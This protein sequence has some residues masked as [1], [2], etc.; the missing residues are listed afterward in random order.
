MSLPEQLTEYVRACFSAIW[1]ETQES[2]EA[3][4]AIRQLCL[5]QHWSCAHWNVDR[6]LQASGFVTDSPTHSPLAAIRAT[7]G[8]TTPGD[9]T[10]IVLENFHRFLASPE[11]V[12]ALTQEI[13]AGKQSRTIFVILA[14]IVQIPIELDKL[15][16][17]VEHEL[18]NRDQL[19][20]IARGLAT[21]ESEMPPL[22]E[23]D[24]VLDAA[25]GL[26]R[27]E[28][29]NAFSLS[30]VRHGRVTS[31]A[32]WEL[33]SGLLKK[34]G[35]LELHRGTDDFRSLGGLTALKSFCQRALSPLSR[36]YPAIRSRGVLL[37]SPPGCGKS[38]FCK[39]LGTEVGRP[40]L[41]LDVGSLMGSLVGQ[42]EERTR[43]ALKI[44][45]AMAPCVCMID[46]VEKAF[47]G[48]NGSGDSGVATRMFGRFLSWLND[49]T[50]DVF[51]ICTANDIT[52][53]PPE[54]GRSERFDGI[55]FLDLPSR[56]EKDAIW[57]IY[58]DQ[59]GIDHD[60]A[61]PDD[62]QWTGAEVKACCRL[63]V[64]LGISLVEAAQNVVPVA[65]TAAESLD[66][67]RKWADGRCLSAH[68]SG[69]YRIAPEESGSGS[70]R[71]VNRDASMN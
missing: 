11:V 35:L 55:F 36:S 61:R 20:E 19:A 16:V 44:I 42:S 12:Q 39:C 4:S 52:C 14:P 43:Q 45:D 37:L 9:T 26:T 27:L 65:V 40:V 58:R 31:E 57:T 46:E 66:R 24:L 25:T 28:A 33:K 6:G 71:K 70:R 34:S 5:K 17:V 21:E 67:L 47:A 49:H 48:V 51:V 18:P 8:L 2:H 53:L 30:L 1:V 68:Q 50:S 56:D 15:F 54:F 7:K 29:E 60:Q 63:S 32:I 13:L 22:A 23:L 10:L 3:L 69:V 41:I 38:Q 64:L 62:S 59:F